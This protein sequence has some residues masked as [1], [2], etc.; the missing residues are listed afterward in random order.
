MSV[1]AGDEEALVEN[2]QPETTYTYTV[3][4]ATMT[5]KPVEVT[6]TAP[7]PSVVFLYDGELEFTSIPGEPS[8]IAEILLHAE[9]IPGNI[10]ISVSA[11][12]QVSTDK[13]S[14]STT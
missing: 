10:T 6:T 8:E 1:P 7:I 14:W 4:S 9:N 5:S 2:L 3:A 13:T 12:F 11:P